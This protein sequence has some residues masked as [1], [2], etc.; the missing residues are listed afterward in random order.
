MGKACCTNGEKR[1]AYRILRGEPEGKRPPE[2]PR[3]KGMDNIKIDVREIRWDGTDW[4]D[5]AQD[6]N[7]WRAFVWLL[8]QSKDLYA[9]AFDSLVNHRTSTSML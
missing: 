2:G 6:R 5:L 4:I 9:A 7:K 3:R 8:Q 1:N